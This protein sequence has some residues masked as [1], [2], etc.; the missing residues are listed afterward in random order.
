MG[1]SSIRMK[2]ENWSE[3]YILDKILMYKNIS[4]KFSSLELGFSLE[5]G[6]RT[7]MKMLNKVLTILNDSNVKFFCLADTVGCMDD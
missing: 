4:N 2:S 1:T 3:K 5:D 6:T 7:D